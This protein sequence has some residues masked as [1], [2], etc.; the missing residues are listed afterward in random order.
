MFIDELTIRVRS[1]AGG[2]GCESYHMRPDR[3]YIP[4]GGDAGN[5]GDI[6]LR[7]D[8]QTGSL[9]AL[10]SKRVF[11]AE[12]GGHGL[13]SNQYGRKGKDYIIKV[14]C[15]TSIH[16]KTENL[17]IRDLI[18]PGE[19]VV[20]LKG[21][22]GGYGNH[23]R[24]PATPGEE[25]RE[26]ELLLSFKIIADIF[27]VGLPNSGKT[28]LL[29]LLTGAGVRE[30]EYPFATKMPRAGTYY[31]REVQLSLC[32]LPSIY[33]ASGEGRG[34]GTRFLKHLE[35]AK[36]IFLMLNSK[37]EFA[38][39]LKEGY[40]ILIQT[41]QEFNPDFLK[42]QRF[43]VVNKTDL[44]SKTEQKQKYFLAKEKVYFI[45]AKENKGIDRLMKDAAKKLTLKS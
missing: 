1:G 14:P 24:R 30:T 29:K 45:S 18:Y 25:G 23:A 41:I 12:R 20:V 19:E 16:N 7:A 8:P 39:N 33:Q 6:I 44:L 13:G 37:N 40:K 3:K 43:I 26:L 38:D 11:E 17:L 28:T 27:L 15:G 21:G 34:L 32:E 5:G 2:R 22:R 10:K 42:I 31:S 4:N 36:L 9:I 35:R